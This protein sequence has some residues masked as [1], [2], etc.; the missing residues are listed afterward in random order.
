MVPSCT[1]WPLLI[2]GRGGRVSARQE[3]GADDRALCWRR[4]VFFVEWSHS[5]PGMDSHCSEEVLR[6][7]LPV[8]LALKVDH[9]EVQ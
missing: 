3:V 1:A 4:G 7:E 6:F 5:D 8:E 2:G 9:W